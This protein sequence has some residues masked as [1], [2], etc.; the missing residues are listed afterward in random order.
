MLSLNSGGNVTSDRAATTEA[1]RLEIRKITGRLTRTEYSLLNI[2]A[3]KN[4]TAS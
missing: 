3:H 2:T 4:V 1:Q